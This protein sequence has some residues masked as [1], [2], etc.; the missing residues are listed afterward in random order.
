[1]AS[2]V[3]ARPLPGH[4]D[5]EHVAGL[6]ARAVRAQVTDSLQRL[7]TDYLDLLYAHLD[8]TDV[9]F[10]ETL[11]EFGKLVDEGLVREI[12]TSNLTA[13]RLQ[14]AIQ[15][16]APHPYRALQQR[17]TYLP[18][19]PGADT[20]P[21]IV[22]D[23]QTYDVATSA[24]ITLVGYSPRLSGGHT[25]TDRC[26]PEEYDT[27]RT[28]ERLSELQTVTDE[29]DGLDAGQVVL[30]WMS[31]RPAR[32][33]PS[34]A[35]PALTRSARPGTPSPDTSPRTRLRGWTPHGHD[36]RRST[37]SPPGPSARS[38]IGSDSARTPPFARDALSDPHPARAT[39]SV[40]ARWAG[41]SPS[42]QALALLESFER[43]GLGLSATRWPRSKEAEAAPNHPGTGPSTV[44][45]QS[46]GSVSLMCWVS[47]HRW[48][49]GSATTA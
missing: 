36:Q 26:A 41:R 44:P 13:E 1:M 25:R 12:G 3:G 9:S 28:T 43:G 27:P 20:A 34:W 4:A 40:V 31:Q 7:R 33:C 15:A 2:K 17:F 6:S 5:L 45:Y 29:V 16:P 21:Q 49:S 35:C 10:E 38:R 47:T 24:D 11:G 14:E 23:P 19:A 30:A 22:L 48:P 8:D 37:R 18:T 39:I 42:S 32:S 46:D